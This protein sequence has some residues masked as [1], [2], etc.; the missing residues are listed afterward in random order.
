MANL[1][2]LTTVPRFTPGQAGPIQVSGGDEGAMHNIKWIFGSHSGNITKAPTTTTLLSWTPSID[3]LDA[4]PNATLGTATLRLYTYDVKGVELG[5]RDY[6]VEVA[7]PSAVVP[8]ISQPVVTGFGPAADVF[9]EGTYVQGYSSLDIAAAASGAYGSTI[10]S[11][12]IAFDG[13]TYQGGHISTGRLT[14][15]GPLPLFVTA[16]DSRGRKA[17]RTVYVEVLPYEPPRINAAP[18]YRCRSDGT[19]DE[20]GTFLRLELAGTISPVGGQNGAGYYIRYRKEGDEE[21]TTVSGQGTTYD[22]WTMPA[23]VT[24]AYEVEVNFAD[25][26]AAVTR[27]YDIPVAYILV[28]FYQTGR[29]ISLGKV[30]S[31]DGLHIA[32]DITT[33]EPLVLM[34]EYSKQVTVGAGAYYSYRFSQANGYQPLNA[35]E[36]Y[37]FMGLLPR[38]SGYGDQWTVTWGQYGVDATVLIHNKHTS[39]LTS[40]VSCAAVYIR[41]GIHGV[42]D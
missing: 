10:V 12:T 27:L 16:T 32:M 42:L 25:K 17:T 39:S 22:S 35:P 4:I 15:S 7:V 2:T 36:G 26:L 41:N 3:I 9:S 18:A 21:W 8:V 5:H 40:T 30:A 37:T 6:S 19:A 11:Q 24:K 34:R 20:E 23:D 33:E 13:K 38:K 28:D 31:H 1:K 14:G 29:G